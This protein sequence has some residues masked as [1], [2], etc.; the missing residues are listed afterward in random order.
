M[1]SLI[2]GFVR[3]PPDIEHG[4]IA[5]VSKQSEIVEKDLTCACVSEWS[6]N[7]SDFLFLD[8]LVGEDTDLGSTNMA[9]IFYDASRDQL[10]K[11]GSN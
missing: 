4:S 8:D 5:K 9:N 11:Q 2:F 1:F 3:H 7:Q 10:L 6:R